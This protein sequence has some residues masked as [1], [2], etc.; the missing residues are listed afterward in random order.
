MRTAQSGIESACARA[1]FQRALLAAAATECWHSEMH[2]PWIGT[3]VHQTAIWTGGGV[4]PGVKVTDR[5]GLKCPTSWLLTCFVSTSMTATEPSMLPHAMLLPSGLN[6]TLSTKSADLAALCCTASAWS[7]QIAWQLVLNAGVAGFC[8]GN[9][10]PPKRAANQRR[11][12]LTTIRRQGRSVEE[13]TTSRSSGSGGADL[14]P[15]VMVVMSHSLTLPVMPPAPA[16]MHL[17]VLGLNAMDQTSV[18]FDS[19]NARS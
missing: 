18:G 8:C 2:S 7:D 19:S 15:G 16:T 12:L 3:T 11:A 17:S 14:T 10:A 5:T 9:C 6:A 1:S 4:S 13:R